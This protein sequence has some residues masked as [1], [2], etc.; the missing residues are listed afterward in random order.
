LCD[1]CSLEQ[2]GIE[3]VGRGESVWRKASAAEILIMLR[4]ELVEDP[5]TGKT[6][7][8]KKAPI[9]RNP[10]KKPSR[11]KEYQPI[12]SDGMW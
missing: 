12:R 6:K 1:I 7:K 5:V 2:Y 3:G 8:K 10:K 11:P 4:M 9:K